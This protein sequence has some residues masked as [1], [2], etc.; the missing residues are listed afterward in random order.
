[1]DGDLV[2]TSF[3]DRGTHRGELLGLPAT[4]REVTVRGINI[5]RVRDGRIVETWHVED[6]AG[7]MAQVGASPPA[8]QGPAH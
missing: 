1:V 2:A 4:G 7:L 6:I 5:E 8:A 3:T